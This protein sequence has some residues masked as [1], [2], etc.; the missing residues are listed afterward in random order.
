MEKCQRCVLKHVSTAYGLLQ[1]VDYPS[2]QWLA[3]GQLVLAE[4]EIGE[5][6]G[7]V[8]GVR[9]AIEQG[10]IDGCPNIELIELLLKDMIT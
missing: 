7:K 9:L 4:W 5:Q 10:L 3:I 1:E 6:R 2:H 8:R